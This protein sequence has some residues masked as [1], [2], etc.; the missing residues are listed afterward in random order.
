MTTTLAKDVMTRHVVTVRPDASLRHA[1]ALLVKYGFNAVPVVTETGEVIGM[2]GIRDLMTAPQNAAASPRVSAARGV[3][4]KFDIWE[5]TQVRQVMSDRVITIQEDT[6]LMQAA[7]LMS[8]MGVHP[9]P[10][11]REGQLVGI[12][13]RKDTLKG[14]LDYAL[15]DMSEVG[16]SHG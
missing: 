16:Q 4:E 6:P 14:V 9:L 1:A 2:L 12:V 11:L 3:A 15:S 5:H 8:N 13:S 7:A 10:V